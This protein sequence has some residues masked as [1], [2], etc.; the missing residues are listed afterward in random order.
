LNEFLSRY[1]L[2]FEPLDVAEEVKPVHTPTS[3]IL[4][5]KKEEVPIA[6]ADPPEPTL[7]SSTIAPAPAPSS[8]EPRPQSSDEHPLTAFLNGMADIPPFVRDILGNVEMAF[9]GEQP[10]A[11]KKEEVVEG[12][13]KAVADG[14]RNAPTPASVSATAPAPEASEVDDSTSALSALSTISSDLALVRESFDF[15]PT[16]AFAAASSDSSSVPALLFN[17]ANSGYHA[18]THKLLQLLLAADAINSN[19]NKDVRRKRKEIVRAV[20]Q[21]IEALEKRRDQVWEQVKA[22]REAGEVEQHEHDFGSSCGSS[23]AD[24]TEI[25]EEIEHVEEV[26]GFEV[27]DTPPVHQSQPESSTSPTC[28][29]EE[30][31]IQAEKQD[32][33]KKS[34][35]DEGYELL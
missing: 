29:N 24:P 30:G 12:K 15:P 1:G 10:R 8:S 17:K 16:L 27:T 18:Q 7:P 31:S 19:G 14:E 22:K 20:E 13:G 4:A 9:K 32:E 5:Q 28:E 23:T 6:V 25:K 21:E 33:I 34:D 11:E 26:K 3:G 2:V 35:R